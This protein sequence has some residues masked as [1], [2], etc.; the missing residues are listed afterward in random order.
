[1]SVRCKNKYEGKVYK[2][3]N[4]GDLVVTEYVNSD[5]VWVKFVETGYE[6][7]VE[8]GQ[9]KKG[10]VKDKSVPELY[11]VGVIGDEPFPDSVTTLIEGNVPTGP[12]NEIVCN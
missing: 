4:Y 3:N 12:T 9:I 8:M 5:K 11:G 10:T 1:M 6:T 7:S 2:T